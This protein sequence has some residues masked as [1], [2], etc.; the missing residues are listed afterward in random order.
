MIS[1]IYNRVWV[2]LLGFFLVMNLHPIYSVNNSK[3][4]PTYLDPKKDVK[5][6]IDDLMSRMT[7]EEKI[8]Q[9]CQFVGLEHMRDAEKNISEEELLTGHARGFYKGLHSRGVE[10]MV[11]EGKISSFLHVLTA[12][13][14]NYLQSL[15]EKSRLK[16]PLLIGI[17]AIHGNGLVRGSTIYPSPI[18]MASSFSPQLVEKSGRQTAL[19]MRATG[20][21][22]AFT[23]NI[24]IARDPR[25]G[26]V[27]ET[28]GEDPYLVAEMG[29]AMVRGLQSENFSG[30]EN[31]IAC[32]KH[33]LGGGASN[34]GTNGAPI[35]I[36]ESELRNTYLYPF[37]EQLK[38]QN[39][40]HSCLLI[41]K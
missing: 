9:M 14:A 33:L 13:E 39:P 24:E 35:E 22:W 5:S 41:M 27:G 26:R 36:G 1:S 3:T 16:I 31:V 11:E 40:L 29:I 34:N 12:D 10:R 20:S 4:K 37:K 6:R 17:D 21:H 8:A 18:T 38:S 25:W 2:I 32:I 30:N 7:L 15:A 23:P 28:F 19:E